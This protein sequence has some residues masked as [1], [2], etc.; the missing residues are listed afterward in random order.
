MLTYLNGCWQ[1]LL[2]TVTVLHCAMLTYLNGCWQLLLC[3]VTVLHCTALTYL[4][5]CWQLLLEDGT[6]E[7]VRLQGEAWSILPDRQAGAYDGDDNGTYTGG[8]D[9]RSWHPWKPER[10]S[11]TPSDTDHSTQVPQINK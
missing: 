10:I 6:L 5:G 1:L 11:R 3:T 7:E 9:D 4:N 8:T 2:C